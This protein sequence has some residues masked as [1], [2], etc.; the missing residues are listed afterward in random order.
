MSRENTRGQKVQFWFERATVNMNF[1][2]AKPRVSSFNNATIA[3]LRSTTIRDPS[4]RHW[5]LQSWRLNPSTLQC[6]PQMSME[7]VNWPRTTTPRTSSN[8]HLQMKYRPSFST[9]ATRAYA[10]ASQ[11][12][13]HP[14]P[15]S[16]HTTASS[17]V[18]NSCSATMRFITLLTI[19]RSGTRCQRRA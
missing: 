1:P 3:I 7:E 10:P 16:T 9:Q 5:Q 15:S 8:H 14:S 13:T 12:K 2:V 17:T 6:N 18:A 11:E 4:S 19:S